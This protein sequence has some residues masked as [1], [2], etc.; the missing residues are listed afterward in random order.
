MKQKIVIA[1]SMRIDLLTKDYLPRL[2]QLPL[3]TCMRIGL[4]TRCYS[5]S[6]SDHNPVIDPITAPSSPPSSL[7]KEETE[8]ISA[9]FATK[10]GNL[11]TKRDHNDGHACKDG[12]PTSQSMRYCRSNRRQDDHCE[13]RTAIEQRN[14]MGLHA[15]LALE[16]GRDSLH[17]SIATCSRVGRTADA[18]PH[19]SRRHDNHKHLETIS[20]C[21]SSTRYNAEHRQDGRTVDDPGKIKTK[22][23]LG[24]GDRD[25]QQSKAEQD[26][27][28]VGVAASLQDNLAVVLDELLDRARRNSPSN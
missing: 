12:H 25:Q 22:I 27:S 1:R 19:V 5:P 17:L 7:D 26:R 13:G 28:Q 24:S 10:D 18:H 16:G 4:L 14:H 20:G 11:S 9:H 2:I 15:Q 6:S 3:F 21:P 23:D 8:W